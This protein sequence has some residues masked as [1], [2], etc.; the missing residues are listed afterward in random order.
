[1]N[2]DVQ[3]IK[4]VIFRASRTQKSLQCKT[5]EQILHLEDIDS[6]GLN[7]LCILAEI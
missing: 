5:V 1:M 6:P 3:D 7:K 4:C 2:N